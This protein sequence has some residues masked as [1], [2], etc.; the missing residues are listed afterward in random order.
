[1]QKKLIRIMMGVGPTHTC[2]DLFKKLAI[3]PIPC[4]YVL[5]LLMF[6]GNN[7]DKFKINNTVHMINTRIN[8]HVHLPITRLSY[9]TGVYYSGVKLFNISKQTPWPLVR[10]QT[11][12]TE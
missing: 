8:A 6:V 5:S 10:K 11:I 2:R 9:Q 1:M 3:L 4:V 7:F 12:P